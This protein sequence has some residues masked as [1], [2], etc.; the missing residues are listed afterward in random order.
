MNERKEGNSYFAL[1]KKRR[2]HRR[3]HQI[4]GSPSLEE[5]LLDHVDDQAD[6]PHE[7]TLV[8]K[9]RQPRSVPT[10][11]TKRPKKQGV[12][13]PVGRPGIGHRTIIDIH[14]EVLN[15]CQKGDL[16]STKED[17]LTILVDEF[18]G[19]EFMEE[20]KVQGSDSTF[21]V[22]VPEERVP[23]SDSEFRVHVSKEDFPS[24]GFGFRERRLCS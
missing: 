19:S 13:H 6:G 15:E 14:L 17:F 3:A 2:R 21:R 12:G 7:Y 10:G 24:S 11:R 5:Q 18:M 4:P 23:S 9:R 1:G 16:H 22:D 8:K 20:E